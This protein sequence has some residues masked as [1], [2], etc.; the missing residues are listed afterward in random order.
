MAFS[1]PDCDGLARD[2]QHFT[3]V[4]GS[5]GGFRTQRRSDECSPDILSLWAA[6]SPVSPKAAPHG[7]WDPS[8][9]QVW[10]GVGLQGHMVALRKCTKIFFMN[11]L[12]VNFYKI[13]II[14]Q[15]HV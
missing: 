11:N 14:N 7:G 8:T 4:G 3:P 1:E 6:P 12:R 9:F 13:D 10:P 15:N 5:V 2:S